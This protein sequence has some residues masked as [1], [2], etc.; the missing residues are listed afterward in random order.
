MYIGGWGEPTGKSFRVVWACVRACERIARWKCIENG[1][2]PAIPFPFCLNRVSF[3]PPPKSSYP[4]LVGFIGVYIYIYIYMYILKYR[5][6]LPKI[7]NK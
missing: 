4:T 5:K 3:P 2:R 1:I 7:Y 6:H